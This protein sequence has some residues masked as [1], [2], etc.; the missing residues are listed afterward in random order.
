VLRGLAAYV[1]QRG[2]ALAYGV[3]LLASVEVRG[4]QGYLNTS[5]Y[6][7]QVLC[8]MN[9]DMLGYDHTSG[10]TSLEVVGCRPSTPSGLEWL[11]GEL[12]AKEAKKKPRFAWRVR[13]SVE[14]NDCHF[15]GEPFGVPMVVLEQAPD[16]TYHCSLDVP[17]NLSEAHLG[18]IGRMVA[19]A[20]RFFAE[21]RTEQVGA[22]ARRVHRAAPEEAPTVWADL[23]RFV[24]SK[25]DRQALA[26]KMAAWGKGVEKRKGEDTRTIAYP[27]EVDA[28]LVRRAQAIVARKAFKGYL[29]FENIRGAKRR[30]LG[31]IIGYVGWGPPEWLQWAVDLCNGRRSVLDIHRRMVLEGERAELAKLIEALEFL[32]KEGLMTLRRAALRRP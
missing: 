30:R 22:L 17:E 16:R 31:K 32:E 21:A 12:A 5:G 1:Q 27:G 10:R 13:R 9:L 29:G 8:G 6:G 26:K 23:L 24:R 19:E 14:V 7:R 2:Q 11:L 15:A 28:A 18:R 20:A 25:N 3:R 4:L